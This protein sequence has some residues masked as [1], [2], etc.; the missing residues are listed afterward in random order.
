MISYRTVAVW[1][2]SAGVG[3]LFIFAGWEKSFSPQSFAD[4]IASFKILPDQLIIP[5]AL[6]I[7]PFEI[8]AGLLALSG[9]HRRTGLLALTLATAVYCV[10]IGL[11]LMRGLDVNCGCF[12]PVS[13][14]SPR[15]ELLRDLLLFAFCLA[16]YAL[17]LRLREN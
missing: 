13:N 9:W 14:L 3:G 7:P 11:A 1:V 17:V 6:S 12:G 15:A 16:S 8:L 5:T 10:A 2:V 4:S